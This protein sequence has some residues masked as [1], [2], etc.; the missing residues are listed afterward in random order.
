MT[1]PEVRE[2]LSRS[3]VLVVPS[4]W[5]ENQPIS[6][7]EALSQ[8]VPVISTDLGGLP[9]LVI[10]GQT[11]MTVPAEDPAA[12]AAAIDQIVSDEP[13][14]QRMGHEG[15]ELVAREHAPLVHMTR[16]NAHYQELL[17]SG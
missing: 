2:L 7:L 15:A 3:S 12:L 5:H 1:Q 8:Q 11:G 14:R 13:R 9:E 16:L 6:I 17:T 10:N 4:R